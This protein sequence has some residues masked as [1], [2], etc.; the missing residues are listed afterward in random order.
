[1][2][3]HTA[4]LGFILPET[5]AL[6]DQAWRKEWAVL[7]AE[8]PAVLGIELNTP[9]RLPLPAEVNFILCREE[10]I[11][12][13]DSLPLPKLALR[14]ERGQGAGQAEI[15]GVLGVVSP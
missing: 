1:L 15:P 11:T 10:Q 9:P 5:L 3:R 6:Q 4:A 7:R 2:A 8:Q 13:L 12:Q 14:S